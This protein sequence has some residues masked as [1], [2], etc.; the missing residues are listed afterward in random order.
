MESVFGGEQPRLQLNPGMTLT[1]KTEQRGFER[2]FSG[3][4]MAIR[5]PRGHTSGM[6]DGPD[7]CLDHLAFASLLLRRLDEVDLR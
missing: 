2:L 3:A 4:M 5:N 6:A 7:T 1:E